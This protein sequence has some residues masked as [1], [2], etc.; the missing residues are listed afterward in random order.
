[1][2][3]FLFVEEGEFFLKKSCFEE[4][5]L[6]FFTAE[7]MVC[8][9]MQPRAAKFLLDFQ[10]LFAL[11]GQENYVFEREF[12][13]FSM[14]HRRLIFFFSSAQKKNYKVRPDFRWILCW[15][16]SC[17]QPNC[18]NGSTIQIVLC[19]FFIG[20][21]LFRFSIKSFS[22]YCFEFVDS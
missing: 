6:V 10:V 7:H 8:F 13:Y 20:P 15:I 9:E 22:V 19:E 4:F 16:L 17:A 1:M 12:M 5:N 21:Y 3:S 14:F 2:F 11:Y 18:V